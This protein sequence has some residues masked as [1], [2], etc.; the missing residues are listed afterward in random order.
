MSKL[1]TYGS[2]GG[3]AGNRRSYPDF[4]DYDRGTGRYIESDPVGLE[5]G[6]NSYTYGRCDWSSP[7]RSIT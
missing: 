5:G 4:K 6:F 1:F 3:A 7:E 2:V